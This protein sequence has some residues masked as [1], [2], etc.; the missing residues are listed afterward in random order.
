MPRS[1]TLDPPVAVMLPPRVAVVVVIE[2]EVGVVTVGAEADADVIDTLS[3]PMPL[4]APLPEGR[5][6]IHRI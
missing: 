6:V 5:Q 4:L 1:V 3:I 2:A